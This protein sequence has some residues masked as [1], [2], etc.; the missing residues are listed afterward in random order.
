MKFWISFS[1]TLAI[2]AGIAIGTLSPPQ[3]NGTLPPH[4]DKLLHFLA[5]ALLALPLIWQNPRHTLWLTPAALIYG[6]TIELLQPNVGRSAEWL[7]FLADAAG[8]A[9]GNLPFIL[10]RKR[11]R[12]KLTT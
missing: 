11:T 4:T 12:K 9:L 1:L 7:D 2:A 8:I 3:D 6:G 5:F 10:S